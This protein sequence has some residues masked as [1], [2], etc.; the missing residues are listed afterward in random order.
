MVNGG[1]ANARLITTYFRHTFAVTNVGSFTNMTVS[2]L[3]DDGVVVWLNNAELFRMNLP[4][5]A[6]TKTTLATAA[7]NGAGETTYYATNL[8]ATSL[9][10]GLNVLAVELHQSTLDSSDAGFDLELIGRGVRAIDLPVVLNGESMS[11][12]VFRLWFNATPGRSYLIEASTD[13]QTWVPVHT[14]SAPG[15]LFEYLDTTPDFW[16]FYR[17]RSGQ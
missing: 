16:R 17:A 6:I 2:V 11:P 1:P 9:L 12:G 7:V 3:R 14:N 15:G 5:G 8:A 10:E 4:G 13:L